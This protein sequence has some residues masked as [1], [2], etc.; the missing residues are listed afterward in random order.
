L[1]KLVQNDKVQPAGLELP[2][3]LCSNCFGDYSGGVSCYQHKTHEQ[4]QLWK[5]GDGNKL[6]TAQQLDSKRRKTLGSKIGFHLKDY[7]ALRA[8]I[9]TTKHWF[10]Q[11][12]MRKK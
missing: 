6:K 5:S 1:A 2:I 8:G 7:G 3:T 9:H 11:R 4:Q 12:A 10:I